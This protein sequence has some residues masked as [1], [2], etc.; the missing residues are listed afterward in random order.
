MTGSVAPIPPADGTPPDAA[1]IA[2]ALGGDSRALD[3]LV[4]RHYRGVFA[5]AFAVVASTADA[6]DICH[7]T[8]VHA[9]ARL[10]ECREPARFAQW[11]AAIARNRARN[12]LARPHVQR[13]SGVDPNSLAA[14]GSPVKTMEQ[15]ELRA[16]LEAAMAL[17]SEAQRAVVLMHDLYG[18]A[19]E[20]I[21]ERIGTS[22]GMSRQHLFKARRRLRETLGPDLL[23]EYFDE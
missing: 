14:G 11:V 2:R 9:L 23:R 13:A 1:I 17:L 20:E 4:R 22:P 5:V 18:I 3:Q 10:E 16:T 7:D 8:F 15:D 6:E 21:A 12:A 19:H